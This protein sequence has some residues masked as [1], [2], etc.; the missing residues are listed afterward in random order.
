MAPVGGDG[1]GN[2]YVCVPYTLD[3]EE[4]FPVVFLDGELGYRGYVVASDPAI[5]Y[6]EQLKETLRCLAAITA[7]EDDFEG[8][9][10]VFD[11][12]K[13]LAEDPEITAFGICLPWDEADEENAFGVPIWDDLEEDDE[14]DE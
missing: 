7:G 9:S 12:E 6:V 11:E 1:C 8:D 10:W 3:G 5:F 2:Y 4:R 13:R 14:D